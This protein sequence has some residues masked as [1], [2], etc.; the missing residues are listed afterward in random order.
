MQVVDERST[1][2][3][4]TNEDKPM[5]KEQCIDLT[6]KS[7]IAF[8]NHS[9]AETELQSNNDDLDVTLSK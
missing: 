8:T 5:S 2:N 7:F 4:P 3:F 6:N 9:E 1:L